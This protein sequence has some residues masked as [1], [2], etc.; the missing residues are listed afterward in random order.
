MLQYI[1]TMRNKGKL[2]GK[3]LW[4]KR[5]VQLN[6]LSCAAACPLTW[7]GNGLNCIC[8]G[9]L[10]GDGVRRKRQKQQEKE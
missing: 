9:K 8:W 4:L 1:V 3:G 10:P 6:A 5:S 7:G 2:K